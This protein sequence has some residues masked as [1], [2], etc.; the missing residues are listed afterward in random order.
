MNETFYPFFDFD[1]DTEIGNAGN[2]AFND[3][4]D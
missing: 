1:K 2:M 4:T 3:I